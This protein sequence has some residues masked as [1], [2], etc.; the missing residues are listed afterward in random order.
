M[1]TIKLFLRTLDV[2]PQV[3]CHIQRVAAFVSFEPLITT[4]GTDREKSIETS[5]GVAVSRSEVM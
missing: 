2:P 5:I 1:I 4:G 3:K